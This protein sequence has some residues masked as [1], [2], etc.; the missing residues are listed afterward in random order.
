[1]R[2]FREN[3]KYIADICFLFLKLRCTDA[4]ELL[5]GHN[6]QKRRIKQEAVF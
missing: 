2:E 3:R 1:M 4:L 5:I 6:L